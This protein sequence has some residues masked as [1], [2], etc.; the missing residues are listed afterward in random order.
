MTEKISTNI[1]H[2]FSN[3][4]EAPCST[5]IFIQKRETPMYRLPCTT[6]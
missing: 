2:A 1:K 4:Y 5:V 3:F 6:A